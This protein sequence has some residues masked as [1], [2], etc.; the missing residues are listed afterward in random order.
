MTLNQQ[1]FHCVHAPLP[2]QIRIEGRLSFNSSIG[3][4]GCRAGCARVGLTGTVTRSNDTRRPLQPPAITADWSSKHCRLVQLSLQT[5]PAAAATG[6]LRRH[7]RA[8]ISRSLS[9]RCPSTVR[10]ALC[11][12]PVTALSPPCHRS[13][14]ALSPLYH[15]LSDHWRRLRSHSAVAPSAWKH[16]KSRMKPLKSIGRSPEWKL[17]LLST[18]S[19]VLRHRDELKVFSH[20]VS[21]SKV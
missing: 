11:H 17:Y 5:G 12:R 8:P 18:S 7:S 3:R 10:S 16:V 9:A 21:R 6:S 1:I 13:V 2:I 20:A 15:P 4:H 19:P 14:T